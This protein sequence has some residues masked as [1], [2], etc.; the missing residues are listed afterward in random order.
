MRKA[1]RH[2][3][4]SLFCLGVVVVPLVV[5]GLA[6][7]FAIW[8]WLLEADQH[9]QNALK[10]PLGAAPQLGSCAS[11]G[12][13]RPPLGVQPL[14]WMLEL[15]SLNAVDSTAFHHSGGPRRLL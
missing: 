9:R 8:L 10:R 1:T 6:A 4:T 7:F 11:S 5:F 13:G 2:K 12:R 15:A 14:S 3:C